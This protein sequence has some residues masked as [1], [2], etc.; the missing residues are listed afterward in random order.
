[1]VLSGI[2]CHRLR[3]PQYE[4]S[5]RQETLT[6]YGILGKS[7]NLPESQCPQLSDGNIRM[8]VPPSLE[9]CGR[10]KRDGVGEMVL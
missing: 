1:M 9:H 2:F 4:L 10:F 7:V 6:N 3:M 8:S 5:L